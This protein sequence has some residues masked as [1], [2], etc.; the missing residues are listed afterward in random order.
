[1]YRTMSWIP[2]NYLSMDV[3]KPFG[4]PK[5]TASKVQRSLSK[6]MA[7]GVLLLPK[8]DSAWDTWEQSLNKYDD[9]FMTQR[10][11]PVTQKRAELD[12]LFD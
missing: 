3:A 8:D 1:M 10:N 11:Q 9:N 7:Q 6:K 4:Y 2:Q 5:H 12:A